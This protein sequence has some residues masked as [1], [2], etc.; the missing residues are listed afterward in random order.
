VQLPGG[1]DVDIDPAKVRDYLLSP[2]H[3]VG[4]FPVFDGLVYQLRPLFTA[5]QWQ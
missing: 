2:E 3:P 1:D 4:L 5:S